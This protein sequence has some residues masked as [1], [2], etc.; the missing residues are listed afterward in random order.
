M[1]E[2]DNLHF[3]YRTS[4]KL[5]LNGISFK[6]QKGGMG[7][8]GPNG[9]GKTTL[10]RVITHFL[11]PISGEVRIDGEV[12]KETRALVGK[13]S[14]VP[15]DPLNMLTG[16]TVLKD[17]KKTT[18]LSGKDPFAILSRFKLMKLKNREIYN[19][20]H[21]QQ[22]LLALASAYATDPEIL[23]LDEPSIGLD[24]EKRKILIDVIKELMEKKIV[25]VA[26]NDM[27]VATRLPQL[28]VL[29]GG[30]I[31][32]SGK[33][34]E[35]LYDLKDEEKVLPN[36]I[37]TFVK[38]LKRKEGIELERAVTPKGLAKILS[39]RLK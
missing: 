22:K 28:L 35:V 16:P 6:I 1:L 20:S 19:L 34:S 29:V 21:G 11:K 15:T 31:V 12:I 2:V 32:A 10:L 27:R 24:R 23:L 33:T 14:Y 39:D 8:I 3:R 36:E 30:Q 38:K 25:L 18:D 9:S 37:V 17:V 4:S 13:V 26:T 5:V 7:L